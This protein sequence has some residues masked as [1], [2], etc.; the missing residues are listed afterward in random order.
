MTRLASNAVTAALVLA[1]AGAALAAPPAA[2]P[3]PPAAIHAAPAASAPGARAILKM[4]LDA[5]RLIDY[6]G[7]KIITALRNGQ[8]ETVTVAE[9]HKRPNLL[10][11]EYLSP[12]DVAGR[13]IVDDGTV[14]QHYEPALNMLFED[15]SIQDTTGGATLTLLSRNYEIVL[16]GTDEVIGRQAYVLS[17]TPHGTGVQRQLWVDRLTGTVLRSEDRDAARGLVLSTYFSRISFSLNLPEAYFRY[18]PPAGARV[19]SLQTVAA[20]TLDPAQLQQQVGFPVLVPPALPEG[21]T[22]RG[23]AVS[24]FGS[25]VSAYLRYSD[26]GNIISFFEAPAGSIGWPTIGLPVRV[27]SQPGRFIDLGYFRVLI[28]EQRGLRITAVGTAPS[29]T[30][31]L[32]AGQ[33]VA[34]REQALVSDVSRRGAADPALVRQLRSQ[35]L[36][37]PEIERTLAISRALGTSVD[38]TVRFVHGALSVT[39]LA[40]QLRM[41]PDVLRAAIRRAVDTASMTPALSTSAPSS[42]PAGSPAP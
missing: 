30:L 13:V 42:V 22:F 1:I 40:A 15:R 18:R 32:V 29:D 27:Q 23:G 26:G 41:Q 31:M 4:A 16:L 37:F 25:L 36:T 6:E 34:G 3:A 8:M 38:T 5:P 19:V 28:W 9:S 7:T 14:A 12:E 21:Y 11:L 33:L 24:R 35:G 20:G 10:R 39:D 17:L 2:P